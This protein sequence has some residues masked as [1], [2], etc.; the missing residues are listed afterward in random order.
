MVTFIFNTL[1]A[2]IA[3]LVSGLG[4]QLT[5]DQ[6]D[7]V[8]S[9]RPTAGG[10]VTT[11]AGDGCDQPLKKIFIPDLLARWPFP[12]RLNQHY[13]NFKAFSPK[14][15]QAFNRCNLGKTWLIITLLMCSRLS[16][17][18]LGCL[19]YPIASE[20]H[21]RS[22]CDYMNLA[23][24][25]DEYSDVSE[26]G[27]VRKQKDVIMDALRHPHKPR[28]KGEWVGGEIARQF[29]E[30][31]I[32]DGA[33]SQSQKRFIAIFDE[34]LEGVVQQAIDRSGHHIRDIQSYFDLRHEVISHSTIE[35]VVAVSLDMMTLS[36]DILSYDLEQA[37]GDDDHNIVKIVMH[38]FDTDVNGA[39]LWVADHHTKL[40]KKY[41]KA[42]AAIPK[43]GEPIDSQVR[44]Y[45]DG[46][47]NWVRAGCDWSF[48][49][50]RYFG[51]NGMEVQQK[52]WI[53][54][55]PKDYLKGCEEIGPVLVGVTHIE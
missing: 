45:C 40:E 16:L 29:W 54:P 36:N 21:V 12:R 2:W 11:S 37:R 14:A 22:A 49:S 31:I 28:P 13:S 9:E 55:M 33:N 41:F 35:D 17:G 32:R 42:V 43:W 48:E 50:E 27:D 10:L 15:Q 25:I 5:M 51:T 46:L 18:L 52:K 47:G 34:Y 30:R 44:E 3:H 4:V 19:A 26:E 20:E 53:L 23:I 6:R 8:A 1:P 38:E 39:M 24:V 7:M